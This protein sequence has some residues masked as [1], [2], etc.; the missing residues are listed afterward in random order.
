MFLKVL[1]LETLLKEMKLTKGFSNMQSRRWNLQAILLVSS[2]S[3]VVCMALYYVTNARYLVMRRLN[4]YT[5]NI[6][7]QSIQENQNKTLNQ[8]KNN[9]SKSQINFF[10]HQMYTRVKNNYDKEGIYCFDTTTEV[11]FVNLTHF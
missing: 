10:T 3:T 2:L 11:L 4:Q 6:P 7:S 1:F 8:H 9:T 5:F